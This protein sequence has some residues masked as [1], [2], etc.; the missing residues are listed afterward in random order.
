MAFRQGKNDYQIMVVVYKGSIG[1]ISKKA[2]TTFYNLIK[3]YHDSED[4]VVTGSKPQHPTV[5]GACPVSFQYD[6]NLFGRHLCTVY[7]FD[8]AG[9]RLD[10][11][12]R[13]ASSYKSE[14]VFYDIEINDNIYW[15]RD[16]ADTIGIKDDAFIGRTVKKR[17]DDDQKKREEALHKEITQST[18][19]FVNSFPLQQKKKTH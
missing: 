19:D 7:Q 16:L 11:V 1:Y 4:F 15:G 17:W 8:A 18:L 3:K 9:V 10:S 6:V 14:P 13:I 2:A 5:D 12:G